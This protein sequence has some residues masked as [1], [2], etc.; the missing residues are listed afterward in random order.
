[1]PAFEGEAIEP[2]GA[3]DVRKHRLDDSQHLLPVLSP[4][5]DNHLCALRA[6]AIA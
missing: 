1:M 2:P 3:T 6:R 5:A 4:V